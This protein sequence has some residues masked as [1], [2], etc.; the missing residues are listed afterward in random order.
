MNLGEFRKIIDSIPPILS[1]GLQGIGEPTMNKDLPEMISYARKKLDSRITIITNALARDINYFE[2]LFSAGLDHMTVS[3]DSLQQKTIDQ[4]RT[5]TNITRLTDR[6]IKLCNKYPRQISFI[7]VVSKTNSKEIESIVRNFIG[8]GLSEKILSHQLQPL[9]DPKNETG[10][11]MSKSEQL[12]FYETTRE[13][14][15]N[16]YK[17]SNYPLKLHNYFIKPN[18]PCVQAFTTFYAT[19]DGYLTP[20]CGIV[21]KNDFNFGNILDT[22]FEDLYLS[23]EFTSFKEN[24]L[25]GKYH[26]ACKGCPANISESQ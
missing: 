15:R 20:C 2:K 26:E 11:V 21:D 6:V 8:L 3:I 24:I 13:S 1:I 23:K 22:K 25:Q 12:T 7:T 5:G 9:I 16:N 14:I 10:A 18:I 19:V 4:L 17:K